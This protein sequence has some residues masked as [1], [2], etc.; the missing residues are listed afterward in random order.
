MNIAS[1]G[2]GYQTNGG[3]GLFEMS[4]GTVNIGGWLCMSRWGASQTSVLNVSGGSLTYAGGG[5]V[6]NWNADGSDTSVITVS[7]SGSIAT[8]NNSV[9]NLSNNGAAANTG[10]LNL[11]GGTVTPAR[12][13]GGRG[14]VNFNGG[15]LRANSDQGDFLAVNTAQIYSGGATI[16]TN[17]KNITINQALLRSGG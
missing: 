4:A 2:T 17:G 15:T 8:S 6:A 12:V 3:N 7:G 13:I 11:N 16:D 5:L 14:F 10:I 1:W 9:I